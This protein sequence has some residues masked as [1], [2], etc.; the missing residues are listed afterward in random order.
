MTTIL[1]CGSRDWR[2]ARHIRE[3]L[4]QYDPAT[5]ILVHGAAR[6]ADQLAGKVALDLGWS[7]DNIHPYPADWTTHGKAAGPIRNQQM[8]DSEP[9]GKV[10]AFRLNG[11]SRGTDD[12]I[13]RARS[14][15][16]ETVVITA[17]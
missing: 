9:I 8:L 6:G 7:P 1:I 16:I 5:T 4:E 14:A 11:P 10:Y 13:R 12:M 3:V 15:G 2:A 17:G